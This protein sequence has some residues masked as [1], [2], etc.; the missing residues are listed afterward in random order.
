MSRVEVGKRFVNK[1]KHSKVRVDQLVL[2]SSGR[3]SRQVVVEASAGA[4]RPVVGRVECMWTG[5]K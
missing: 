5:V 3:T 1:Q 2:F 4:A